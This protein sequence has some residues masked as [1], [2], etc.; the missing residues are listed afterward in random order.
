MT[1]G[2][3][4]RAGLGNAVLRAALVHAQRAGCYK[5]MLA[6]GSKRVDTLRFYERAGF[7][8][9]T[10]TYFDVRLRKAAQ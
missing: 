8:R 4:R 9:G 10:R 6:T 1:N 2:D 3:H 7:Q 5:V